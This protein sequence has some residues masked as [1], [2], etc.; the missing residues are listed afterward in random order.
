MYLQSP[1]IL[2]V[3]S[4]NQSCSSQSSGRGLGLIGPQ[5]GPEVYRGLG[6]F[7]AV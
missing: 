3:G 7:R 1:M 2:Q 5:P 4:T 6:P